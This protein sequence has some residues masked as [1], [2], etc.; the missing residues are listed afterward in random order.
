MSEILVYHVG[1]GSDEFGP[2]D[3]VRDAGFP[4]RVET[5]EALDGQC[6]DDHV[7]EETF[8]VNK[9]PLSS[10]LLPTNPIYASETYDKSG[11]TWGQNTEIDRTFQVKTTT[12]DLV[13]KEQPDVISIDAQGAEL[14]ILRGSAETLRN[15]LCVVAEVEFSPIYLGQPLYGDQASF[16]E[17]YGFRLM[18]FFSAQNWHQGPKFGLGFLTV[19]EAVWLRFD[20]EKLSHSRVETLA[21][22]AAGFGRLSY[23]LRL[24]EHL[25]GEVEN[26]YLRD[27]W[28]FK[29]HPE[30]RAV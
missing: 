4:M 8:Y 7:G 16:L 13:A 14:R 10:G 28:M 19:A 15:T 6:I 5:F 22:I 23:A 30:L 29:D 18:E 12:I 1:G 2:I 11:V 27:L 20:Y 21:K 24:L 26:Q 25:K 3:K 9:Y 17:P